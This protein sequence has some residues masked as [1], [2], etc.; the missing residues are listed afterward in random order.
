MYAFPEFKQHILLQMKFINF[1]RKCID[2]VTI[3][4][5]TN[6][7]F[8]YE[9]KVKKTNNNTKYLIQCIIIYLLQFVYF[10]IIL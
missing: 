1:V 2:K 6:T 5:V 4:F 9:N 7:D 8:I 3:I 10:T